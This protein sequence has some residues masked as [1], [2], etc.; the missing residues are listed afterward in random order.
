MLNVRDEFALD[1]SRSRRAYDLCPGSYAW[2]AQS[3]HGGGLIAAGRWFMFYWD[4]VNDHNDRGK[5]EAEIGRC[6]VGFH[7]TIFPTQHVED[8]QE[9]LSHSMLMDETHSTGK[10]AAPTTGGAGIGSPYRFMFGYPHPKGEDLSAAKS[11]GRQFRNYLSLPGID[12][13]SRVR[14]QSY[15]EELGVTI[16]M[17]DRDT[18]MK[19]PEPTLV[20]DWASPRH[21]T[22]N[23]VWDIDHDGVLD[24][25]R[26]GII[27]DQWRVMFNEAD[28][29]MV[30][31]NFGPLRNDDTLGYA[32]ISDGTTEAYDSWLRSGITHLIACGKHQ[33]PIRGKGGR[34]G[35]V[36]SDH[37][38]LG[39]T[40]SYFH[41]TDDEDGP[42]MVGP[43]YVAGGGLR[44][45]TAWMAFDPSETHEFRT[46]TGALQ[47]PG[48]WKFNAWADRLSPSDPPREPP[49]TK[50]PDP[51]TGPPGPQGPP[52][53][54][55]APGL[56]GP[57]GSPIETEGPSNTVKPVPPNAAKPVGGENGCAK[58]G[59]NGAAN[60]GNNGG[61]EG[62]GDEG[63]NSPAA[64]ARRRREATNR[65]QKCY[66]KCG[67]RPWPKVCKYSAFMTDTG[68]RIDTG[69][70]NRR[71]GKILRKTTPAE[72][73]AALNKCR[74]AAKAEYET[75]LAAWKACLAKCNDD[76]YEW[77]PDKPGGETGPGVGNG[78]WRKKAAPASERPVISAF[79][80]E[81]LL[82]VD[83]SRLCPSTSINNTVYYDR[84]TYNQTQESLRNYLAAP[85]SVHM[86]GLAKYDSTTKSW[87][88]DGLKSKYVDP[89][90]DD[91]NAGL[92]TA[93]GCVVL[94]P[95]QIDLGDAD[96][97]PSA[98]TLSNFGLGIHKSTGY[99]GF[100]I[101]SYA[102]GGMVSGMWIGMETGGLYIKSIDANGAEDAVS[103]LRFGGAQFL[104]PD[105]T[106]ALPSHSFT[107]RTGNGMY[108]DSATR[109]RFSVAGEKALSIGNSATVT[110]V[111]LA[112]DTGCTS[113]QLLPFANTS[114]ASVPFLIFG[115]AGP[116]SGGPSALLQVSAGAATGSNQDGGD[117]QCWG[118][119]ATGSGVSG[120]FIANGGTVGTPG[121]CLI[122]TAYG[123]T[124]I[125]REAGNTTVEGNRTLIRG[126]VVG[127]SGLIGIGIDGDATRQ[128]YGQSST[129]T[130]RFT[131]DCVSLT[132]GGVSESTYYR[133]H[134]DK[135]KT[136]TTT[137]DASSDNSL[138]DVL[139]FCTDGVLLIRVSAVACKTTDATAAYSLVFYATVEVNGEAIS[140]V[141]N[142]ATAT[143][144]RD[145]NAGDAGGMGAASVYT[146]DGGL[147]CLNSS[148]TTIRLHVDQTAGA[149][150]DVWEWTVSL[151]T[152]MV[153]E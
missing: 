82:G 81:K 34:D 122:G 65:R 97:N 68:E 104:T 62:G 8:S 36:Y 111:L 31:Q 5:S 58:N 145:G 137:D 135:V 54:P 41:A 70:K 85:T 129:T 79:G 35:G 143:Y 27:P 152:E 101:P 3:F 75:K 141:S 39:P 55:G 114:A 115:Q 90:S 93:N 18:L 48:A 47:R 53:P 107:G 139:D 110:S 23:I 29:P 25:E 151:Q 96:L 2:D 16:E 32:F 30:A 49:A 99:L 133:H 59:G 87:V 42:V 123:N 45:V 67:K 150:T 84:F 131:G 19:F 144:E 120:D 26:R 74:A 56:P 72:R 116:V 132:D 80:N 17:L 22:S 148:G 83:Y 4:A 126:G 57:A 134:S 66:K 136:F 13:Y 28:L 1:M 149:A 92:P 88:L 78:Y 77:V 38:K 12:A 61:N 102:V 119:D 86:Q 52:G 21:S 11:Q 100:G 121:N 63:D 7:S 130:H 118:G 37:V 146:G 46:H 106:A 95:P 44:V 40:G 73:Q 124:T 112:E 24:R 103:N 127:D 10:Q 14:E 109:L 15:G 125:G 64:R 6:D 71:G 105:G 76:G 138:F 51:V 142:N 9:I 140:V 94:L 33:H 60:G 147:I 108:S 89:R 69:R 91:P 117:F 98:G 43:Q 113:Y 153:R 50:E 128:F 20:S